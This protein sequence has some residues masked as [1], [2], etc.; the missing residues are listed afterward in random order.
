MW[1]NEH[2]SK[3][4]Q[5]DA[6]MSNKITMLDGKVDQQGKDMTEAISRAKDEAIAASQQGDADTIAAGMQNAKEMDAQLRADLM[7]S[8][9]M[10]G[11]K[12]MDSAKGEDAKLQK[13]LDTHG[14]ADMA[15]DAAIEQLASKVMAI[16]E[17]ISHGGRRSCRSADNAGYRQFRQWSNRFIQRRKADA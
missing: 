13:Q 11:Q 3:I 16:E 14:K 8:I 12:A 6:D 7:K 10:Q 17:G 15:Q 2:V 4:E 1:K 9:D 5:A